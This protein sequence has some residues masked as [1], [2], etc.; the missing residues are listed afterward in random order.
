[1]VDVR[2]YRGVF[3]GKTVKPEAGKILV[4]L[5]KGIG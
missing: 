3:S 5:L 1:M 2:K 4:S